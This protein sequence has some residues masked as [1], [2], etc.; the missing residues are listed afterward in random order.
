MVNK[1]R[2]EPSLT[3]TKKQKLKTN[4]LGLN[5]VKLKSSWNLVSV[6]LVVDPVL[7]VMGGKQSQFLV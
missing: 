7:F 4:K 3:E 2:G 5:W 6:V 1:A